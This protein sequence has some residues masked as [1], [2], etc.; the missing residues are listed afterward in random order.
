MPRRIFGIFSP[1]NVKSNGSD[2]VDSMGISAAQIL[3]GSIQIGLATQIR[4]YLAVAHWCTRLE[5][6][7]V[8]IDE[9]GFLRNTLVG[10]SEKIEH[11][12]PPN[13]YQSFSRSSERR[14]LS[15]Y[16]S[17]DRGWLI[18]T[19]LRI[20]SL[21]QPILF[22]K[23]RLPCKIIFS[24]RTNLDQQFNGRCLWTNHKKLYKSALIYVTKK[25]LNKSN[26]LLRDQDI[27]FVNG[28]WIFQVIQRKYKY[29]PE[30]VSEIIAAYLV[31]HFN[32]NR[33]NVALYVAQMNLLFKNYNVRSIQIPSESLEPYVA[34][35]QIAKI[36]GAKTSLRI[37]GHDATGLSVPTLR[38]S[39]GTEYLLDDFYV[40]SDLLYE[41]AIEKGFLN[42]QMIRENSVF[43]DTAYKSQNPRFDVMVMTWIPNNN[44]PQALVDSPSMTLETTLRVVGAVITGKIAIKIKD[45]STE[46]E[47]VEAVIHKLCFS[48]RIE[49]L[50]GNFSE[51][52]QSSR[53]IIGGIGS[54]IAEAMINNV[55][56][57]A[58]EPVD[59]G[60]SRKLLTEN[61]VL[62]NVRIALNERDLL[63]LLIASVDVRVEDARR[64]LYSSLA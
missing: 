12:E 22:R 41:S 23:T 52:V 9:L 38:S 56:Y 24:D 5:K 46:L 39:D 17:L 42:Y 51:H 40:C 25:E 8:P 32:D 21:V 61:N 14:Q 18:Q 1:T 20:V 45:E 28:D 58:Y 33:E 2:L 36:Q 47:Y 31:K 54:A 48:E 19:A 43:L 27:S 60:Y 44:N 13:A 49:I 55:P 4:E 30:P 34:A 16:L 26:D 35:L 15:D 37:D 50:M 64:Y 7:F 59:N 3:T 63:D 53:L 57:L 10:L 11:Y 62:S 29:I 6:I